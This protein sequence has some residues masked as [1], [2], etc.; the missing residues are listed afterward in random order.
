MRS[1]LRRQTIKSRDLMLW[2]LRF[3]LACNVNIDCG[4]QSTADPAYLGYPDSREVQFS[5]F[6][7]R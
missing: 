3:A 4:A 7:D 6:D 2:M 1:G 5:S